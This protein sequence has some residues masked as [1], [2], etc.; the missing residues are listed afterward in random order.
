[1]STWK[2]ARQA[3]AAS[4]ILIAVLTGTLDVW[5]GG[6]GWHLFG[7]STYLLIALVALFSPAAIAVQVVCGQVLVGSLLVSQNVPQIL[8]LVPLITGI[9]VTAELLAAVARMDTPLDS[10]SRD[11]LPRAGAAGLMGGSIFVVVLLL[12]RLPGPTGMVAIAL[13]SGALVVLATLLVQADS[14]V[15]GGPEEPSP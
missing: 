10:D 13:A 1:M 6:S 5:L 4:A 8:L 7:A 3:L 11:D 15:R 2:P 9:I 12:S 14:L